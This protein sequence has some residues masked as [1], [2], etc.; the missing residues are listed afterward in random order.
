MTAREDY[1]AAWAESHGGHSPASGGRAERAWFDVV[2][3]ISGPLRGIHP[4]AI[5]GTAVA[6]AV[7]AAVLAGADPRL[8]LLAAGLVAVSAV[9]DGVDGAVAVR[10][11]RATRWGHLID[12][13]G[14]RVAEAFFGLALARAGAPWQLCAAAV[15][16]GWLQEYA[17]AR[18]AAGGVTD[19]L[20][21]T[22]AERPT[23]V[24]ATLVGLLAVGALGG[25][26]FGE[27]DAETAA[28]CGAVVWLSLG[29]VGF[30][31]LLHA[32]RRALR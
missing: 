8:C 1:L 13:L 20:V 4:D 29:L 30:A 24:I 15:A 10:T 9:L 28:F 11:G 22:V 6:F 5:T 19:I 27:F 26:S 16:C 25:N 14:D 18:A 32:L 12:S 3:R 31:Q 2:F 17:R 23:R 21:V 7:A